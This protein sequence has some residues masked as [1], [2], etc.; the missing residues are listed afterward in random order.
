[1][2]NGSNGKRFFPWSGDLFHLSVLRTPP[3]LATVDGSRGTEEGG[4]PGSVHGGY[5]ENQNC[6]IMAKWGAGVGLWLWRPCL[7]W[8]VTTSSTSSQTT[9]SLFIFFLKPTKSDPATRLSVFVFFLLDM[10]F[11]Q[12]CAF[13][14]FLFTL[15]WAQNHLPQEVFPDHLI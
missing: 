14:L 12:V 6:W 4:E 13:E 1:M 3:G 5:S 10:F 11:A 7:P 8:H 9:F 2:S 15:I